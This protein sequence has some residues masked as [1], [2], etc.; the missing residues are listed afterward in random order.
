MIG[1]AG[2]IV[3]IR[4]GPFAASVLNIIVLQDQLNANLAAT[5]DAPLSI[6]MGIGPHR[7]MPAVG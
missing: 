6:V 1:R 4:A 7:S 5:S 2:C 3:M